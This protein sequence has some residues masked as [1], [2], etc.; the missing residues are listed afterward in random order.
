MSNHCSLICDLSNG[1]TLALTSIF[2]SFFTR[3]INCA[4]NDE[5][6]F[7]ELEGDRE[8]RLHVSRALGSAAAELPG[9]TGVA[10]ATRTVLEPASGAA[11][12]ALSELPA[13]A[14]PAAH[15]AFTAR[16]G[17]TRM[18]WD[19]SGLKTGLEEVGVEVSGRSDPGKTCWYL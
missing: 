13:G 4:L 3:L 8:D 12:A 15:S 7:D 16:R 17:M 14:A 5:E 18:D 1:S 6:D 19:F 9:S 11:P 2:S 10:A